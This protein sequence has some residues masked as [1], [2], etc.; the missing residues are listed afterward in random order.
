MTTDLCQS[1]SRLGTHSGFSLSPPVAVALSC[2]SFALHYS[3]ADRSQSWSEQDHA[4]VFDNEL[5]SCVTGFLGMTTGKSITSNLSICACFFNCKMW[6]ILHSIAK[7]NVFVSE[8]S[9]A[10]CYA[11]VSLFTAS[12]LFER[13]NPSRKP[14]KWTAAFF[15]LI[16]KLVFCA[17]WSLLWQIQNCLRPSGNSFHCP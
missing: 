9:T 5:S 4:T 2:I 1:T 11:L 17:L 14:L 15:R 10:V 12:Q 16:Y 6:Q 8:T 3:F 7:F 13:I